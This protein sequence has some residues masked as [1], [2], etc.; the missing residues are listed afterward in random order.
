MSE[1]ELKVLINRD[2]GKTLEEIAKE[3]DV[4]REKSQTDRSKSKT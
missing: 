1:R 4:T 2:K 3:I